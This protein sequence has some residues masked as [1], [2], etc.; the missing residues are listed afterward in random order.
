VR[1]PLC[2]Q[3]CGRHP[4]R[5]GHAHPAGVPRPL[6]IDVRMRHEA[7]GIDL[8]RRRSRCATTSTAAPSRSASTS[9]WSPPVPA[10][11]A[12]RCRAS[13]ST[14]CAACRPST[15]PTGCSSRPASGSRKVVVVGGGYIGLE[16]AEAF[17]MWGAEVTLLDAAP[18]VMRTLDPDMAARILP[19][20]ER[21]GV[22]VRLDV[23][24]TGFEPRAVLTADG[25]VP[26]TWWC[27]ASG[28]SPT[29]TIA[30]EAGIEVGVGTPSGSTADSTPGPRGVGGGR[31]RRVVP[32]GQPAPRPRGPRH[33]GQQAGPGGRASTSAAATPRS[34]VSS[35]PPSPGSA[36][37]RS[38]AP[39]SPSSRRRPRRVR[40][41]RGQRRHHSRASYFPGSP[42]DDGEDGGRARHRT[43]ARCP[44]RRRRRRGQ[45]HR[46]ARHRHHGRD[47]RQRHLDLDL[48][49]AP[50]FSG[51]WD[52]VARSRPAPPRGRSHAR[53]PAPTDRP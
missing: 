40:P 34:P 17:L 51:V 25:S 14:R 29:P 38:P 1:H 48:A 3:R 9:C 31:L 46:H 26:P 7:M 33:R 27:S 47:D 6:R 32:P 12:R 53:A 42:P 43:A 39:V 11:S 30:A 22:D 15:T 45:A 2:G 18:Q 23:K 24:V 37:P 5:S 10:R 41:R 52:A 49:Y 4:R 35:A 28:S 8:D 20:L 21:R 44:D 36:T 50:P 19:E 13:T 16:M